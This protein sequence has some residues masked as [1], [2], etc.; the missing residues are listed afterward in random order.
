MIVMAT[1]SLRRLVYYSCSGVVT[2]FSGAMGDREWLVG[3]GR[4][5]EG[6]RKGEGMGRGELL[7]INSVDLVTGNG[8]R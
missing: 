1:I 5:Q 8:H 2:Y 4:R 6:G 7:V 3:A